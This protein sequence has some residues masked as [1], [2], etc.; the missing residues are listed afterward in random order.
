LLK[1]KAAL[2][3]RRSALSKSTV[4]RGFTRTTQKTG[5][6]RPRTIECARGHRDPRSECNAQSVVG[7]VFDLSSHIGTANSL[8]RN[9][10]GTELRSAK[11]V[12]SYVQR[13]NGH[14][15]GRPRDGLVCSVLART[16][17]WEPMVLGALCLTVA[18]SRGC[19][20]IFVA[21]RRAPRE[22]LSVMGQCVF[23]NDWSE[24]GRK[25]CDDGNSLPHESQRIAKV[26]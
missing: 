19:A 11:V 17:R 12:C 10:I 14:D 6:E 15:S 9:G 20:L 4:S 26:T 23:A 2:L 16:L 13:T 22:V 25:C 24:S 7:R 1:R 5:C 18:K 8:P 3:V 21:S